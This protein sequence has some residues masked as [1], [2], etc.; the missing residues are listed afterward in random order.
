MRRYVLASNLRCRAIVFAL[1]L[2][3]ITTGMPAPVGR[4][5]TEVDPLFRDFY[6]KY[7]GLRVL[8][9]PVGGLTSIVGFS[10][11]YFEKGR[12]EDH[13]AE[14]TNPAWAFL[15]GR[16]VPEMMDRNPAGAVSGT[17]KRYSDLRTLND[18]RNRWPVPNGYRPGTTLMT[19]EGVFVPF[20][21]QLRAVPGYKVPD[22]L[23]R[24]INQ[25][26]LFPGGWLHDIGLPMTEAFPANVV[27]NGEQSEIIMQAFERTVLTYDPKNPPQWQIERANIGWDALPFHPT[28]DN[29]ITIPAVGERVAFPLHIMPRVGRPGDTVSAVVTWPSGD[30]L[31]RPFTLLRGED[32]RG[33]LIDDLDW[34]SE[35]PPPQPPTGAALLQ[36]RSTGGVI[37]AQKQ[38]EAL[39]WEDPDFTRVTLYWTDGEELVAVKRPVPK[40]TSVARVALEEL[41][42]GPGPRTTGMAGFGTA[43]PTPQEV[44]SFPGRRPGWGPR[45]TLRK[46]TIANGVA[47]ADFSDELR[48]YGGGS[49]RV[50]LI[51]E[52]ITRTLL[53]FPTV[54]EVVIA[55]EGKT[56]GVL[57][58]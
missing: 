35:G 38:I 43:L 2:S 28:D 56:E 34:E 15:Y 37:L 22:F 27:K 48:A 21:A 9:N 24:Y 3:L 25:A 26:A 42:W 47:T 32:G 14:T 1:L 19:K 51:R 4:A 36:I 29:P 45:V 17:D 8:G 6:G 20:D 31:S 11:Q 53:E 12:I 50:T 33:L 55:I 54:K 57:E 5:A 10:A 16:L 7:Q 49:L 39:H 52:Q 44:L 40:T 46:L 13:R 41:L 18:P 58:P 23:W 30:V